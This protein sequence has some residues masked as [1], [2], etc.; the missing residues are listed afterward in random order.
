MRFNNTKILGQNHTFNT[1]RTKDNGRSVRI[2]RKKIEVILGEFQ[3]HEG[4]DRR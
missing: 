1:R 4:K 2:R 3:V